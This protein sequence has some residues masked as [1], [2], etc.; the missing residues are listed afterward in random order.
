MADYYAIIVKFAKQGTPLK[1]E[2][3]YPRRVRLG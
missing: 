1:Q 2:G 3:V